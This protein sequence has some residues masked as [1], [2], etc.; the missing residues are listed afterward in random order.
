MGFL[1]TREEWRP[2]GSITRL[3]ERTPETRYIHYIPETVSGH[4]QGHKKRSTRKVL[5][6]Q[7]RPGY[8]YTDK[9]NNNKDRKFLMRPNNDPRPAIPSEFCTLTTNCE[10]TTGTPRAARKFILHSFKN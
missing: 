5:I 8:G 6:G 2:N 10:A 4:S 7:A 3:R 1:I 9:Q